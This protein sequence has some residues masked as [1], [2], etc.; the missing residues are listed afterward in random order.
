MRRRDLVAALGVAI[1]FRAVPAMPAEK[2][3]RVGIASL[4]NPRDAPQFI[5]FEQRLRELAAAAGQDVAVDFILLGGHA[6]RYPA[7]MQELA[8]RKPDVIVAPGPEVSLNAARAATQT[9]P[10]VMVGVD[11]DPVTR[12]YVQSMAR[13]GGNIT[14]VYLNTVEVAAKRVEMLRET[15][16]SISRLI[17]FWDTAGKDSVEPTEA[18]ARM[19][20]LELRLIEFSDPPYDYE[21]LLAGVVPGPSD[22]LLCT[23]SPYF[24]HD[25]QQLDELALRHKL[26][27]M[28]GGVASGGL[29]AYSASLNA[30]FRN[31][32]EY[33][34]K[35]RQGAKPSELPIQQPTRFKLVVDLRFAKAIGVTIPPLILAQADEVI[36]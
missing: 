11:Y 23:L 4:I 26:P 30:L 5:A 9:I 19:L 31:A 24:F 33:A 34:D 32:A 16:P 6:D 35:I 14:G 18:A 25:R 28:C 1:A 13:P 12:G 29:I 22:A 21:K 17:V 36:E 20:G 7:A 3:F 10:I 2:T 8:S 15:V 27:S